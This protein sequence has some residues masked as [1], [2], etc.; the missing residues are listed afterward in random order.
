MVPT[1][2]TR[3]TRYVSIGL[4]IFTVA[5][6]VLALMCAVTALTVSMATSVNRELKVLGHGYID[7]YAALARANIR[8]VERALYI[9]R[10]YINARDGAGRATNEELRGLANAAADSAAR[11]MAAAR[12][13][14]REEIDG[15]S[16]IR[17][18]VA[19]SR[20]DTLLEG[21]E[22]RRADVAQRQQALMDALAAAVEPTS[23]RALLASLDA[24]REDYDRELESARRELFRLV[25]AAADAAQA[26]QANVVKAVVAITA[27]AGVLGLLV[28]GG[29][30]RG[31]SRPVRRLLAGTRAVQNGALDTVVPVTSRDEIGLLTGAFNA[32]VAELK[33][34]AQIKET[35]GKYVDPRIV[36][37]LIDR[38]EL[39]AAKS[40]RRVMTVLFCDMREWTA[41][42]E[43]TTPAGLVAII[44]QYFT[45]MSEPI[46]RHDG[47]IDKYIGDGIMAFWGPPFVAADQQ[48]GLACLA[49][50]DQLDGL[51]A[52]NAALPELVG[53][54]RGLP[55]IDIRVGIATGEVL[56]GSIGSEITRSYTVMGGTV[57]LASRLDG[58]SKIYGTRILVSAATAA[59]AAD[60]VELREI[61]SVAI[62]GLAEPERVFE[63][64]GRAGA[65]D[66]ATRNLRDRYAEG[67]AAHRCGAVADARA[68]LTACLAI[69]PDDG[70]A[71]Q[72]LQRLSAGPSDT[73]ARPPVA[74]LAA[75]PGRSVASQDRCE[76]GG[77]RPSLNDRE[78]SKAP[79]RSGAGRN[80]V[81]LA[82][83]EA[84]WS[85]RRLD[86]HG[87]T[88][89]YRCQESAVGQASIRCLCLKY[90][91]W[92]KQM[93]DNQTHEEWLSLPAVAN[94]PNAKGTGVVFRTPNA[95]KEYLFSIE[96]NDLVEQAK[97]E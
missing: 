75:A 49:A 18:P 37:G 24:E 63:I 88:T 23:L 64:L 33:L 20:L 48:A 3:E 62:P 94:D 95:N 17:D 53:V 74:T 96:Y 45:V 44:N 1:P 79:A 14:L 36:Q 29:F 70:P 56:V 13:F 73:G 60:A 15:G 66:E 68:A 43:F 6:V 8:S 76:P 21:L 84:P 2:A 12:Q 85:S 5:L 27:L 57:N 39:A 19:L 47:I 89:H 80:K 61:D 16:A 86:V 40:E 22:H 67:L 35:F 42:G 71:T 82:R 81:A 26:Q 28:A 10:L 91:K 92:R 69:R 50:L 83:F 31:L 52:L 4:K 55:P 87:V 97:K 34:K 51:P 38:P 25:S 65:I 41:L 54:R 78:Q 11:E 30:S 59:L 77:R 72:L 9:R 93:P 32:M 46:R 7:S 90:H 58:I